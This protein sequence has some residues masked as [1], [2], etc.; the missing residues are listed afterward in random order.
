MT[1]CWL[2]RNSCARSAG[3]HLRC[4]AQT[5]L[6]IVLHQLDTARELA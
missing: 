6:I 5:V 3:V 2:M 1:L 4:T